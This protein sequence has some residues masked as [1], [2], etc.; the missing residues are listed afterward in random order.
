MALC[1]TRCPNRHSTPG[2]SGRI[3]TRTLSRGIRHGPPTCGPRHVARWPSPLPGS[4]RNHREVGAGAPDVGACAESSSQGRWVPGLDSTGRVLGA[5]CSGTQLSALGSQRCS[6]TGHAVFEPRSSMSHP[7]PDTGG[8][9][10]SARDPTRWHGDLLYSPLGT[11]RYRLLIDLLFN[12]W[13][14]SRSSCT[15][16][17]SRGVRSPLTFG[18]PRLSRE[19]EIGLFE[20]EIPSPGNVVSLGP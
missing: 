1:R 18:R 12:R 20:V 6:G 10:T 7:I 3:R 2:I 15:R 16:R 11:R 4:L 5:G 9:D 8:Q 14:G 17:L 13:D 19:A